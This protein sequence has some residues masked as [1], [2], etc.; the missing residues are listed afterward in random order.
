MVPRN[1]KSPHDDARSRARTST[2][3]TLQ[4]QITQAGPTRGAR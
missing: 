4:A 2:M 1:V 3:S